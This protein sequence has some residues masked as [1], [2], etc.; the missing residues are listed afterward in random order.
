MLSPQDRSD[1]FHR[2]FG[3]VFGQ[4]RGKD[5]AQIGLCKQSFHY[6]SVWGE[7]HIV[8]I[9]SHGVVT[10]GLQYAHNTHGYLVAT[11]DFSYR[12]GAVGK[13]IV[14]NGLADDADFGGGA[15]IVFGK[16]FAL[17]HTELADVKVINAYSAYRGGIVV[18]PCHQLPGGRYI[19]TD[20]GEVS[21]LF[22]EFLI[23]LQFQ[24]LHCRRVLANSA[25]H[26]GSRMN[27]NHVR[28]H[29]RDLLLDTSLRALADGK[30]GDNGCYA[31]DDTQHGEEGAQFVVG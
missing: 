1:F 13:K 25:A 17:F 7:Y 26:L 8:L 6:G 18:R 3:H 4:G 30:H 20:A 12:V 14:D 31:D 9:L 24:C 27:H 19:G 16:H 28:T 23:I 2:F 29:F 15:D 10:F 21:A 11:D 5:T 22:A